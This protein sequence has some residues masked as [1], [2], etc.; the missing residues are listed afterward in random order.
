MLSSYFSQN[1]ASLNQEGKWVIYGTMGGTLV[2]NADFGQ[3]LSKRASI[4]FTTLRSRS[5]EYK[6]ELVRRFVSD[7]VGKMGTG[8]YR[9]I[10]HSVVSWRDVQQAHTVLETSENIG[11]V[12]LKID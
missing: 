7:V 12:V 1:I 5:D 2:S 11:K 6:A 9:P 3:L 10:V 8:V 4:E